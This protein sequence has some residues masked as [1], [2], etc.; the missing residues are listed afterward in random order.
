MSSEEIKNSWRLAPEVITT[1]AVVG[2]IDPI[3][4][5]NTTNSY[6]FASCRLKFNVTGVKDNPFF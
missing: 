6:S 2:D 4:S 1:N 5:E 3:L